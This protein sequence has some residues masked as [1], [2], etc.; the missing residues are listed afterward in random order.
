LPP[1]RPSSTQMLAFFVGFDRFFL[2]INQIIP[3]WRGPR[4]V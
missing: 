2:A 4:K 3:N 1:F